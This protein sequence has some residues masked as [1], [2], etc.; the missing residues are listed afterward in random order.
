RSSCYAASGVNLTVAI[1]VVWRPWK[2]KSRF[3]TL[4]NIGPRL[5]PSPSTIFVRVAWSLPLWHSQ[6]LEPGVHAGLRFRP[7]LGFGPIRA[8]DRSALRASGLLLS[9]EAV[10]CQLLARKPETCALGA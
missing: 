6:R 5:C 7:G 3:L 8:F 10:A 1:R 9:Q 2:W 4:S